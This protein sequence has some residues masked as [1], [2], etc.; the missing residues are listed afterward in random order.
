MTSSFLSEAQMPLYDSDNYNNPVNAVGSEQ[1]IS[2]PYDN[3]SFYGDYA[4][5]EA[6]TEVPPYQPYG[7]EAFSAQD[8]SSFGAYGNQTVDYRGGVPM[9]NNGYPEYGTGENGYVP[10]YDQAPQGGFDGFPGTGYEE[11]PQ[12]YQPDVPQ[13]DAYNDYAAQQPQEGAYGE[14]FVQPQA[15]ASS[16]A[17][18][19]DE[20]FNNILGVDDNGQAFGGDS[21][22]G[23]GSADAQAAMPD[24]QQQAQYTNPGQTSYRPAGSGPNT[25]GKPTGSGPRTSSS[26]GRGGSGGG[27]KMKLNR[28]GYMFIA[29]LAILLICLI[30]VIALIARGCSKKKTNP[31]DTSVSVESSEESTTETTMPSTQATLPDPS[32]PIGYFKFSDYTG[33]RT[34]WDVFFYVYNEKI[35]NNNDPRIARILEYNKLDPSTYKGP[36]SGDQLLLPPPGVLSGEIPITW[37]AGTGTTADETTAAPAETTAPG[38]ITSTIHIT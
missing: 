26:A 9:D 35:D 11:N 33:F 6:Q 5:A 1:N 29:F 2:Q 23:F 32:A 37:N 13:Q 28:N 20:W 30:I 38:E 27:K 4:G 25:S 18:L 10:N 17:S 8:Q 3:A 15:S 19:D 36:N 34:W 22:F 31:T 16:S 24:A 21:G 12:F 7:A 14:E